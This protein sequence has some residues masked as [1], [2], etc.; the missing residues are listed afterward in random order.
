[1]GVKTVRRPIWRRWLRGPRRGRERLR[2]FAPHLTRKKGLLLSAVLGIGLALLCIG[3]FDASLRPIVSDMASTGA[4]NTI[5]RVINDAVNDTLTAQAVAYDD[6]VTLQKDDSG[7]ITA[8]TTSSAKMNALRT[9]ILE[10]IIEQVNSLD[11]QELGIPLG[12]LTGLVS[13]SGRGPKLPVRVVSVA[14][15]DA[16]FRNQ[17]IE[18]G[19]NQTLHQVVLDVSVPVRL[20]IPGGTVEVTV[21][22]QVSVAETVIV[23][24]VPEAYLQFG[25]GGA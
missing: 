15:A 10:I 3:L 21:T 17:F 5:T 2:P 9:E 23:G 11:T 16:V 12:N 18:A 22:A 1:M 6:M 20:L 4:R 25:G 24:Q 8:M 13:A 14:L 7:R 19:I